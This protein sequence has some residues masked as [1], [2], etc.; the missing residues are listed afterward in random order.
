METL[1]VR[2]RLYAVVMHVTLVEVEVALGQQVV[3]Q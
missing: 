3:R 2:L 1:E